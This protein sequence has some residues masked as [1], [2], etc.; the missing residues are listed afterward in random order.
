[1]P[2]ATF[3]ASMTVIMHIMPPIII[4]SKDDWGSDY[5]RAAA[6]R[7]YKTHAASEYG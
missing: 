6:A 2:M 1:M 5:Y 4:T 3:I 7:S